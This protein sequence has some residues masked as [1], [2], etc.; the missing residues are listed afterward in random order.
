MALECLDLSGWDWP[1]AAFDAVVA[2]FI[3]FA[4]PALRD[5]IFAGMKRAVR[6]GGRILL[7]GYTPEQLAHGT[8]GP[9]RVDQLYTESLLRSAFGDWE[10]ERL[11]TYERE[12]AEGTG[13]AGRSALIDLIARRPTR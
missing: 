12:L 3:Q 6:P 13:H 2:I 4:P 9:P 11:E 1:D 10:I 7:H 5:T 8:G